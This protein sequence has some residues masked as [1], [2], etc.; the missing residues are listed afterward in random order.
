VRSRLGHHRHPEIWGVNRLVI[1]KAAEP[2]ADAT[3]AVD[4]RN[5]QLE[6]VHNLQEHLVGKF[7]KEAEVLVMV[8][9]REQWIH[10]VCKF[11]HFSWIMPSPETSFHL[12]S[13]FY[14]FNVVWGQRER[15]LV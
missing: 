13:I 5:I 3:E 4:A 10:E 14:M 1:N 8:D 7:E 15:K 11:A 12:C 9:C 2:S 6:K